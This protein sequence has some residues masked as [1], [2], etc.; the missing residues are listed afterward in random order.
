MP[1]IVKWD[2]HRDR[3]GL[4]FQG[5]SVLVLSSVGSPVERSSC[6]GFVQVSRD[7]LPVEASALRVL[8]D[9]YEDEQDDRAN[10]RY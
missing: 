9:Q 6:V 4:S 7:V 2:L 3:F 1:M 5:L 10:D 8:G